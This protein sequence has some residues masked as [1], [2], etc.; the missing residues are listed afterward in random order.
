MFVSHESER[1]LTYMEEILGRI[2]NRYVVAVI[3]PFGAVKQ[4]ASDVWVK[5]WE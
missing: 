3:E 5:N 1:S 2:Y 4:L